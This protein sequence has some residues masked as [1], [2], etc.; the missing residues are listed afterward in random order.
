MV[1]NSPFNWTVIIEKVEGTHLD[2]TPAAVAYAALRALWE[3]AGHDPG[4]EEISRLED[5]VFNNL[6]RPGVEF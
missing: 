5:V 1:S 3:K 2:T 6:N 4:T